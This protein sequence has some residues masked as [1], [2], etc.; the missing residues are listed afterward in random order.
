[1]MENYLRLATYNIRT[2]CDKPPYDWDARCPR[3]KEV[4]RRHDLRLL[5]L[6]EANRRQIEDL[7]KDGLFAYTGEGRMDPPGYGE[8]EFSCIL[9]R[10]DS[11][12][13]LESKTF[14]LSETPEVPA[15][16]SWN[17]SL[18]RICTMAKIKD[19]CTGRVF[20]LFN[21]HLDHRS[22]LA[23]Q[24]GLKLILTKIAQVPDGIPC[25]LTGDFNMTPDAEPIDCVRKTMFY[26]NDV[27]ETPVAGP[28][29]TY[30]AYDPPN[31]P[32]KHQIDYI[33]M[34]TKHKVLSVNVFDDLVD[35]FL[36]SDH[37]PVVADIVL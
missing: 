12:S 15:S 30:N 3:I 27:S 37:Y 21:T 9:Y 35:G 33:F 11:F 26:T 18:A 1:M 22:D 19:L 24:N 14:W 5:G 23:K 25:F 31:T 32:T 10:K 4:I 2:L 28:E 36:P 17:T 16:K 34:K 7:C 6:Q 29:F 20:M 13:V 8:G